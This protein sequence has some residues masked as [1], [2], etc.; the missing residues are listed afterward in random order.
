MTRGSKHS[1]NWPLRCE[2]DGLRYSQGWP[3]RLSFSYKKFIY[4][5]NITGFRYAIIRIPDDCYG[6]LLYLLA[7]EINALVQGGKS[8]DFGDAPSPGNW[9]FSVQHLGQNHLADQ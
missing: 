8:H 7:V 6:R 4:I 2:V 5:D 3:Q 1:P 9:L